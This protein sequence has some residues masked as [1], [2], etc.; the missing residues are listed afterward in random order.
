MRSFLDAGKAYPQQGFDSVEYLLTVGVPY[1]LNP[2][3][4]IVLD[5]A[6][7]RAC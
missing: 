5:I 4:P 6:F 7:D 2:R 1:Y 3:R